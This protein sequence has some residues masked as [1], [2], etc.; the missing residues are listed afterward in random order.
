MRKVLYILPLALYCLF[1]TIQLSAQQTVGL[2]TKNSGEQDG[3]VLFSPNSSSETYLIDKCGKLVHKWNT[4]YAPGLDAY[5]LPNGELLSTGK[6][7]NSYFTNPGSIGGLV[8]LFDWNNKL[9]W[10]YAISDSK[11]MENHDVYPMPNGN[12]LVCEW[13][14][15]TASQAIAMGRVASKLNGSD[16]WSI[17]VQEIKPVNSGDTQVVW[18]WHLWDHLVQDKDSTKPNYATVSAHPEL[19][20]INYVD[21]TVNAYGSAD[22]THANAVTYNPILDQIMISS[23]S[24]S[25]IYI[26]DHSTTTAQ[27]ASHSGGKHNKGGDFLYRWGNPAAYQRGSRSDRTLFVQHN[28]L[29]IPPGYPGAGNISVFNDGTGRP[30]GDYS[31]A[32]IFS[33]PVDSNGNYYLAPGKAYGPSSAYWSYTAPTPS[34]FYSAVQGGAEVLKN[35]NV[36]ICEATKGNFFEVDSNKNLVWR[37]V[38][39]DGGYGP[40]TQGQ[41]PSNIACFKT[42]EYTEDYPAFKNVTLKPGAPLELKPLSNASNCFMPYNYYINPLYKISQLKGYN[43][44]TGIVD[45]LNRGQGF[46]KGVV[47]SQNFGNNPV[48]FA[49]TDSTGAITVTANNTYYTPEI[50]DSVLIGGYVNQV[51][52]L[53]EYT[54]DTIFVKPT[55]SWQKTPDNVTLLTEATESDLVKLYN[56]WLVDSTQW[57][58]K[59]S[60]FYVQI[61]NGK[62]TF[63]MYISGNTELFNLKSLNEEFNVTGI[64]IQNQPNLP[65]F[66][67]Y[68]IVPRG[69]FDI[70]RVIQTYKIRQVRLQNPI[71][72]IADSAGRSTKFYLKGIVQSPDFSSSSINFSLTDS[73]G[74]IIV[75]SKNNINTYIPKTGDSIQIKGLITQ[76]H[77]LTEVVAD[78]IFRL[79]LGTTRLKVMPI[80]RMAENFEAQLIKLNGYQL[81][82]TLQWKPFGDGFDVNITNGADTFIMHIGSGTDLY[83]KNAIRGPF[84]VTGIEIQD[85]PNEPYFGNYEIEPRGS[86]DIQKTA[87][88]YKISQV[89]KQDPRSG[90][91]DSA[92]SMNPFFLKGIVQSPDFTTSGLDFSIKDSTGS[93]IVIS[94]THVN[95]YK[96]TIGDSI[97]LR[98][99]LTQ[100]NGLTEVITDSISF[101]KNVHPA[102]LPIQVSSLTEN[103]EARLISLNGYYLADI[104]QWVQNGGNFNVDITNGIDTI[105]MDIRNNTNLSKMAAPNEKFNIT[106]IEI[107][108]QQNAPFFGNYEIEPRGS[109]D[110]QRIIQLYS[111]SQVRNQNPATG[112]A[113]S[114]GSRYNFFVKGIVQSPDFSTTGLNFS[115]K[116]NTGSI[117]I[118]SGTDI[119]GYKPKIG[120]SVEVRGLLSQ[121]EGLTE[122]N[123]DSISVLKN[124][125]TSLYPETVSGLSESLEAKLVK[126]YGYHLVNYNQWLQNGTSFKTAITNG[127][128]TVL[129]YIS[130]ATNLARKYAP[131]VNFD[132]TGI[133]IQAQE[134]APYFG[135]YELE[136]RGSFD[137]QR[138]IPLY[139]ISQVRIQDPSTG[140]ADSAGSI[141]S[142]RLRGIVQSPDFSANGLDFSIKDSTGSIFVFD[143]TKF[144][145]YTPAVGD[146]IEIRGLLIQTNGLTKVAV[147]SMGIINT[148]SSKVIPQ[149]TNSLSEANEAKLVQFNRAWLINPG[150]WTQGP[151]GFYTDI[152]NG[153]D[154]IELYI[155]S[156]TGINKMAVPKHKFNVIGIVSQNKPDVPFLGNYFMIPRNIQDFKLIATP[157][158]KIRQIKGYNPIS[159]IADSINTYCFIKG[160]VQSTNLS[161]N[162][163]LFFAIQ[164]STGSIT[165]TSNTLINGYNPVVGDSV[166]ISGMVLQKNGLTN[167]KADSISKISVASQI[168]PVVE[169]S[170]DEN[171]ESKLVTFNNYTLVDPAKWD[172]TGANGSFSLKANNGAD[173]ITIT[174]VSGT[175]LYS[176]AAKPLWNL[177]DV[178][179]IGSQADATMPYLTGYYLI[180]RSINDFSHSS[181]IKPDINS[182]NKISIYPNPASG[183]I[184]IS[185]TEKI[186]SIEIT[187]LL[188]KILIMQNSTQTAIYKIDINN[189]KQG[190]Y[191]V[192]VYNGDNYEIQKIV[193]NQ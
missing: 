49:I 55:G 153:A 40:V 64:E 157:Y 146:S 178:T 168:S 37:Y 183:Y 151:N 136:P 138:E 156:I 185:S 147:D 1:S 91:A 96:P 127:K 120:D 16:L 74:S 139:K 44:T 137:F 186:S 125:N 144:N 65:Y 172:T 102:V 46:I 35:G 159:G 85:Q 124:A 38:N 58:R 71:T 163:S 121:N 93:I 48:E 50:G 23:R 24:M 132:V 20:N 110:L 99:I 67:N 161:G 141:N 165:I 45:S 109:Y 72:G 27:A 39:P 18:E 128:D 33:P 193:K 189:L 143:S 60:G 173:T 51:N 140:I 12:I 192:K 69:I 98:G 42:V 149:A 166:I 117:I 176:N 66:G 118:N 150:Q 97:E 180:P 84:N 56:V 169:T 113:D 76:V 112:I 105:I 177:F 148:F 135:N 19:L 6:I 100:Y 94:T 5:L 107:Q 11:K 59:G 134:S 167:L 2:F 175:D 184:N 7:T 155:N 133:E 126:L 160:I 123:I 10:K 152:T 89:R 9:I 29:W 14:R 31:S 62:D 95:G 90:I 188:G 32:D 154:T 3:Y 108:V 25:E 82:D 70:E 162:K 179:G 80:T 170:L 28:C 190:I 83:K 174:I 78:T 114:A 130:N 34:T 92:G 75:Y 22:W 15:F 77:G 88:L 4:G 36:L 21:T 63:L 79:G 122:I 68:A 54:S 26:I 164:D 81:T 73:T 53:T 87:P 17:E 129:L 111:I 57:T 61:T 30:G 8:Q 116:D 104:S 181:A 158:Y 47:E 182:G 171:T 145:N 101:L 191:L 86:F 187:D 13:E 131:L 43:S 106:G 52:G 103:Y 41:N 142:F 119:Y 115:L